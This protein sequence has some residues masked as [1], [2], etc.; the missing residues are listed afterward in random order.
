[1]GHAYTEVAGR[2]GVNGLS[3][4]LL[5]RRFAAAWRAARGFNHSRTGWARLVDAAFRGLTD[6]P[7]SRTFFAELYARFS[8]PDAWRIF[9]DVL[10]TLDTLAARGL[11][12][13]IISNWDER[14][15]PLL[16][17]LKLTAHFETIIVSRE[18]GASKP[19]RAI[20]RQAAR[21]LG[22][23]PESVLHVGD[24]LSLDVR[25]ARAAGLS[26]LL[27]RRGIGAARAGTIRSLR[28][29]C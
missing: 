9:P 22:V 27:L 2:H 15:R 23:A 3:A 8:S 18:V 12:L 14:L 25:G 21:R 26:A 16:R 4:S 28:E 20:F 29:L 7:P 17:R 11:K 1:V 19:S 5:N 24:D 10:P 6:Q 13:G